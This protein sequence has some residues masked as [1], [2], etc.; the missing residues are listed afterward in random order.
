M[1][2]FRFT[3]GDFQN[4][5]QVFGII[6]GAH[7][8][9][10]IAERKVFMNGNE[11]G[12]SPSSGHFKGLFI[13]LF[14]LVAFAVVKAKVLNLEERRSEDSL[15]QGYAEEIKP[16]EPDESKISEFMIDSGSK[17]LMV[18]LSETE[19]AAKIYYPIILKASRKHKVDPHLIKAIIVAESGFNPRA[20]SRVGARGLMQIM[21]RT[22]RALGLRDSFNPEKN[23][24]AG[25]RHFKR[26]LIRFKGN[27]RLALA[28]YNAGSRK[29]Q[30]HGGIPPTTETIHFVKKV[31]RLHKEFKKN[32]MAQVKES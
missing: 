32:D 27:E 10:K 12:G 4:N 9:I 16:D 7:D 14:L 26:L 23:I 28:A 31:S 17:S 24:E 11:T 13:C 6:S 18:N 5:G 8:L 21:P 20:V 19:K 29:V 30:E 1:L 25:V 2:T 15:Q 3:L 22:A